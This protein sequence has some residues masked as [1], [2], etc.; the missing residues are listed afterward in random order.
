MGGFRNGEDLSFTAAERRRGAITTNTED[1]IAL[2]RY[3]FVSR[4]GHDERLTMGVVYLGHGGKRWG[5]SEYGRSAAL[6]L[7]DAAIE[8]GTKAAALALALA[9]HSSGVILN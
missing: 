2:P 6:F 4:D 3:N 7:E 8:R 5:I 1:G 9:R